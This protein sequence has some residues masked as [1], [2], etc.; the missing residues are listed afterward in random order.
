MKKFFILFFSFFKFVINLYLK[1]NFF[2]DFVEEENYDSYYKQKKF[3]KCSLNDGPICFFTDN[4]YPKKNYLTDNDIFINFLNLPKN[5]SEFNYN[6][7]ITI[8][9]VKRQLLLKTLEYSNEFQ[10]FKKN[11]NE[12]NPLNIGFILTFES[13]DEETKKKNIYLYKEKVLNY[14]YTKLIINFIGKVILTYAKEDYTKSFFDKD[15]PKGTYGIIESDY[16]E[17]LFNIP[18]TLEYLYIRN[19]KYNGVSRKIYI[20]FFIQGNLISSVSMEVFKNKDNSWNKIVIPAGISFTRMRIPGGYEIDNLKFTSKIMEQYNVDIHFYGFN[21][22]IPLL[23]V[24]E[25]Y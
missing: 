3:H 14:K 24:N 22:E 21:K 11:K 10:N 5:K 13:Y 8:Y 9:N 6:K 15:Y 25:E 23:D 1:E 12:L 7:N 17:V 20:Q 18:M 2:I 4:Y 19:H 16:F